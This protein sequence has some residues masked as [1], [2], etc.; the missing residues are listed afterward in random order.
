VTER[1]YEGDDWERDRDVWERGPGTRYHLL[2]DLIE[3]QKERTMSEAPSRVPVGTK[4][5]RL[6]QRQA[7]RRH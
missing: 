1:P 2:D 5:L 7:V 3:A 4:A 6:D